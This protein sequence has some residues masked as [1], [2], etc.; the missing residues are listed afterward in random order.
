VGGDV[1]AAYLG[2]LNAWVNFSKFAGEICGIRK[3]V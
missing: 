3:N 2:L 1:I